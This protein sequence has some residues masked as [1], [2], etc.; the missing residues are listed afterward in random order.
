[1]GESRR[2]A[3]VSGSQLPLVSRFVSVRS[4]VPRWVFG[5]W[6]RDDARAVLAK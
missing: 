3:G 1:M 5:P 4:V 6:E 2:H